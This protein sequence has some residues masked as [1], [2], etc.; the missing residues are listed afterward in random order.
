MQKL[1]KVKFS[2][3]LR[4]MNSGSMQVEKNLNSRVKFAAP[5]FTKFPPMQR[6]RAHVIVIPARNFLPVHVHTPY[7]SATCF[8]IPLRIVVDIVFFCL[9]SLSYLLRVAFIRPSQVL[10]RHSSTIGSIIS[11]LLLSALSRSKEQ[12]LRQ[13]N[14][15]MVS[16]DS[17][18]FCF[19]AY[20]V[21]F[22]EPCLIWRI[23]S[24]FYSNVNACINHPIFCYLRCYLH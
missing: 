22:D 6:C 8:R 13:I 12:S 2:S 24:L 4:F 9:L 21:L 5:P 10:G 18:V 11:S 19:R 16:P 23:K 14:D 15:K 7:V 17:Q 3:E 20:C 1:L